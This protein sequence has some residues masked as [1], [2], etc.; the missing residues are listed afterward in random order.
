MHRFNLLCFEISWS[1][2]CDTYAFASCWKSPWSF[3][4]GAIGTKF[5]RQD[6]RAMGQNSVVCSG[7]T[8]WGKSKHEKQWLY[9]W[10][11]TALSA[12]HDSMIFHHFSWVSMCLTT[13]SKWSAEQKIFW[14]QSNFSYRLN[15]QFESLLRIKTSESLLDLLLVGEKKKCYFKTF[16]NCICFTYSEHLN[17]TITPLIEGVA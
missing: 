8:P 3:T 11:H 15:Q 12:V 10:H 5:P 13:S 14:S 2:S 1:I 7:G 16:W 4:W 6:E 17:N 9:R